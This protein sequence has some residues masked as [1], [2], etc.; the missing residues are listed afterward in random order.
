LVQPGETITQPAMG[1]QVASVHSMSDLPA[2]S[3]AVS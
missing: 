1:F 2:I 3:A